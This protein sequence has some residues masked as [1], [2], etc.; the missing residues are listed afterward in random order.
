MDAA[1]YKILDLVLIF[2]AVIA[3]GIHQL[4]DVRKVRRNLA[5]K[6]VKRGDMQD[7]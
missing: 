3:F 4:L 7:G 6:Q 2:G 5:E 1:L